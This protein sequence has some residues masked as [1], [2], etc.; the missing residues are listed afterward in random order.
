[1]NAKPLQDA[2][3]RGVLRDVLYDQMDPGDHY[4][5]RLHLRGDPLMA[6]Q[7]GLKLAQP[8]SLPGLPKWKAGPNSERSR[9]EAKKQAGDLERG[10]QSAA[11]GVERRARDEVGDLFGERE[12]SIEDDE[13]SENSEGEEVM[14]KPRSAEEALDLEELGAQYG[15]WIHACE[16]HYVTTLQVRPDK[17]RNYCGR[18]EGVRIASFAAELSAD[19]PADSDQSIRWWGTLASHLLELQHCERG[20][21]RSTGLLGECRAL[22][23][24][25]P[26][27]GIIKMTGKREEVGDVLPARAN[28]AQEQ[29][30][31]GSGEL[32]RKTR[33]KPR[34]DNE[35]RDEGV[36][37][38]N[39]MGA[40]AFKWL[41]P[42]AGEEL[43]KLIEELARVGTWPWQ[44]MVTL[45]SLL[46]TD[47]GGDRAIGWLPEVVK[48]WSK[49]RSECTNEWVAHMAGK[50]GAAVAGASALREALVRSFADEVLEWAATQVHAV[51]AL[52]DLAELCDTLE[53]VVILE[54]GL[55]LGIP[56]RT[57][58]LEMLS[59][60]GTRL[61]R[62]RSAYAEPI[63][64]GRSTCAGARRGV[65]F[66]RVALC[67][68]LEKVSA[69][70]EQVYARSRVDDVTTRMEGA[71]DQST[72]SALIG[73]D[74]DVAREVALKL[75]SRNITV[76]VESQAPDL[77]IDR[78]RSIAGD[79]GKHDKRTAQADRQVG[80]AKGGPAFG[81]AF[82]LMD[83]WIRAISV[84]RGRKKAGLIWPRAVKKVTETDPEKRW[85]GIT[86]VAGAMVNALLDL[87]WG[88]KGPWQWVSDAGEEFGGS[89]PAGLGG[90]VDISL[91][92]Q[93]LSDAIESRQWSAA[94]SHYAGKGLEDGAD[95]RSARALARKFKAKGDCDKV[96]A[97][98][99]LFV[100]GAWP[101]QRVAD[102]GIEV[103]DAMRPRCGE[104]PETWLRRMWRC[105]RNGII[106]ESKKSEHLIERATSQEDA[107]PCLWLRCSL[108][109][110]WTAVSPPPEPASALFERFG[111][112]STRPS[113][114]GQGFSEWLLA[115]GGA[116][117]GEHAAD[118]RLRGGARGWVIAQTT[119]LNEPMFV[120]GV[121]CA[122][123][124]WR[125]SVNGGELTARKELLAAASGCQMIRYT[126]DSARAMRGVLKLRR[127]K[128]PKTHVGLWCEVRELIKG[129]ELDLVKIES[130]M[131]AK[132]VV[133]AG[134]DPID[135]IGN[136]LAGDFADGIIKRAQVPRAQA[137]ALGFAERI[138]TLVRPR[139]LAT[140]KAAIEVE[141]SAKPSQ[142]E[143]RE[144]NIQ[145]RRREK[146]LA[147][148]KHVITHDVDGKRYGCSRRGGRAPIFTAAAWLAEERVPVERSTASMHGA[149]S[150]KAQIARRVIRLKKAT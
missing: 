29:E 136:V 130:H 112:V 66:G 135:Y 90:D 60:L 71:A 11:G 28:W 150:S 25:T 79:K 109:K 102:P 31:A 95:L 133:D 147:E 73:G 106:E 1:M 149:T 39:M 61:I 76:R 17:R 26:T 110:S 80:I 52:W 44:L 21:A 41:P 101:R 14:A 57:L 24:A 145:K 113:E 36:T 134:V 137:R 55:R 82:A 9:Q 67:A 54:D 56:A 78:G 86:G 62:A 98:L 91:L 87:G 77:G 42:S 114:D 132:D 63:A 4:G 138:A 111:E 103:E 139:G 33:G 84:G 15:A 34:C 92:K 127:G 126:A 97:Q 2:G 40:L 46:R 58:H 70:Y 115:A 88:P 5:V 104:E 96:W 120:A 59:H 116:S 43:R 108:P 143:R 64:P 123:A 65:D 85:K 125:Q 38:S 124:G 74:M 50:W 118:P 53:P 93:A 99:A 89:D 3:L 75:H 142:K 121:R 12:P 117:G 146:L 131:S 49:M 81:A 23:G 32:R 140:L 10:E 45:V 7:R 148:T 107:Q 100:G 8:A 30:A 129:K 6:V 35:V 47:A 22:G 105:K 37:A 18:G 94:A 83:S 51:T 48:L 20:K 122:L 141:P 16:Q 19:V 68:V 72:K 13:I 69:K 144:A 27:G 119:E 128:M